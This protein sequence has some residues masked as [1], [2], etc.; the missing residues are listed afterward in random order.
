MHL[1]GCLSNEPP[2]DGFLVDDGK[3][4]TMKGGYL[5]DYSTKNGYS[6]L[7]GKLTVRTD[8]LREW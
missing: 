4:I 6:T 5:A 7:I 8:F 1:L 2:L 3:D